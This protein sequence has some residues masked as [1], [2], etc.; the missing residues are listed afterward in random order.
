MIRTCAVTKN[1]EWI[2]D[3]NIDTLLQSDYEW[4]WVDFSV[5]EENETKLL[6]TTFH[7]HPLAI[8]DCIHNLQRPKLDYYE[9]F[10]FFV[11]HAIDQLG[12]KK[13]ELDIFL[14]TNYMV[15]YHKTPV[16]EVEALWQRLGQLNQK[17][18][19]HFYLL[20]QMIDNFVDN[21]FPTLY[22]I[23]DSLNEIEDNTNNKSMDQLLDE[24]FDIRSQ[25]LQLRHTVYPMRDLLYRMLNS[26]HLDGIRE[27]RAYFADIYDHLLKLTEMVDSNR[28][29]TTDIRDSYLSLNT[30]QTNRIMQVLTVITTIFM[31]LTFIAGV[32]GMNFSYI[33]EL[34]WHY[35]YFVCLGVMVVIAISMFMW[36]K[37][38]GWFN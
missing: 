28:E 11:I 15:T 32:Y 29:M 20:H 17:N 2:F 9:N 34:K 12:M 8:E 10:T 22:K 16:K 21:Y 25:L 3:E 26:T 4:F 24:L 5:P 33:P 14:G 27:R 6:E 36:F 7:F 18:V 13:E 31:P 37:R 35:S 19:D 38:K 30:H 1:G 23:E